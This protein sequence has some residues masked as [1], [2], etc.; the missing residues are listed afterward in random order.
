MSVTI[1]RAAD[2]D[3]AQILAW[4][5][6]EYVEDD[7]EGFWCNRQIIQ[8]AHDDD[9]LW[10]VLEGD[11]AVAFQVGDYSPDIT[12]VRKDRRRRGYGTALFEAALA[13]A[14]RDDV[15]LLRVE[16]NPRSSLPFWQKHGFVRYGDPS[17]G[18]TITVRRVLDRSFERD[19][20]L[21]PVQVVVSFYPEPAPWRDGV[22]PIAV[23]RIAGGRAADGSIRLERRVMGLSAD[24]P[25]GRD[26]VVRIEF[27]GRSVCFCK[28]KYPEARQAGVVYDYRGGVYFIDVITPIAP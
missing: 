23:H 20:A 19:P 4:L 6:R 7:G 24:E 5:E 22:A 9:E 8:R 10:V 13:R 11:E 27:E 15:N 28:A 2:G 25:E 17:D 21:P 1:E 3:L 26:L 14:L 12:N 16:C 18:G